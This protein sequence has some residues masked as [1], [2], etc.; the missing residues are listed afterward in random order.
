M[1]PGVDV[2]STIIG[3]NYATH[4]GTS[5]ATPHVAGV[6][7]LISQSTGARGMDLWRALVEGAQPLDIPAADVGAGL[8]QAPS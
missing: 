4:S 5:M 2:V 7:A 6:G 8:V 3:S 1:A